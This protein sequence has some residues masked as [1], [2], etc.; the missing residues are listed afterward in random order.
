MGNGR[1]YER[2]VARRFPEGAEAVAEAWRSGDRGAAA[3]NVTDE[4]VEALGVAG[5]P[6]QAREQFRA[7]ADIDCVTR[8]MVTVPSNADDETVERTVEA[9]APANAG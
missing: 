6:E 4:M 5:T 7:V 3:E 2:A 8:P 9:L 1:G